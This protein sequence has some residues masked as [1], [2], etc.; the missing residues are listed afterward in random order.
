MAS[1][2]IEIIPPTTEA[3]VVKVDITKRRVNS[4]IGIFGVASFGADVQV[5]IQ[6]TNPSGPP[7]ACKDES[8]ADIILNDDK[9]EQG[10][11][12]CVALTLDKPATTQAVDVVLYDFN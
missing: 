6:R 4:S 5:A 2:F 8:G 10:V 11:Y 7:T 9:C 3:R 1:R 12:S